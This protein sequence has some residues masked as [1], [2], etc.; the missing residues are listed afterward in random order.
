VGIPFAPRNLW[1]PYADDSILYTDGMDDVF[2]VLD[3]KGNIIG[4]I[5]TELPNVPPIRA[6]DIFKWR[7]YTK[8]L[9]NRTQNDR[10]WYKRFGKVIEEYKNPLYKKK[11]Y[12]QSIELTPEKN[13]LVSSEP[14]IGAF[15][16]NFWLLNSKGKIITHS[17]VNLLYLRISPHYIFLMKRDTNENLMVYCLKRKK[18]EKGDLERLFRLL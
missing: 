18:T 16:R 10:E 5:E 6:Q 11:P 4:H 8:K 7:A 1:I 9:R 2:E 15:D 14:E 3:Y 17:K 13:I 12:I